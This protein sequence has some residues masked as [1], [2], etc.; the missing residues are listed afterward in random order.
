MYMMCIIAQE[1]EYSVGWKCSAVQ[2][3]RD[4]GRKAQPRFSEKWRS[5]L[6]RHLLKS[7]EYNGSSKL[8]GGLVL[9]D[10]Y[11]HQFLFQ[12]EGFL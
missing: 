6:A 5:N 3:T 8:K 1:F 9:A 12:L 2:F 7:R 10:M 11:L 4:I